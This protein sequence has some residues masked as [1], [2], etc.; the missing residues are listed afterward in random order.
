MKQQEKINWKEALRSKEFW[1]D[2]I[3]CISL[4]ATFYALW[5]ASWIIGG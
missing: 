1:R 5:C 2:L 4:F 3:G